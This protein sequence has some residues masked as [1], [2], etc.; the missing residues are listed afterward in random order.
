MLTEDILVSTLKHVARH[1]PFGQKL[2]QNLTVLKGWIDIMPTQS[3]PRE[4]ERYGWVIEAF[5]QT[6]TAHFNI[7]SRAF[8]RRSLHYLSTHVR[9]RVLPRNQHDLASQHGSS[10]LSLR[11]NPLPH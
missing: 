3:L 5:R 11:Q 10:V 2:G 6:N 7:Q 9:A 8:R 4:Y 1:K